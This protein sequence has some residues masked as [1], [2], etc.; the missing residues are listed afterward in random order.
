MVRP[1]EYLT[2][3]SDRELIVSVV[4][5]QH[6]PKTV[7]KADDVQPLQIVRDWMSKDFL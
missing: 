1:L 5:L 3:R 2:R 4:T 6:T 7:D